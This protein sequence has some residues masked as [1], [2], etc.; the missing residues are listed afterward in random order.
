MSTILDKRKE[1]EDKQR[2]LEQLKQKIARGE[3]SGN[4]A[5]QMLQDLVT[6]IN[7]L[8]LELRIRD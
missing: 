8:K 5:P 3:V 4:G 7:I 1:L 2:L 6:E